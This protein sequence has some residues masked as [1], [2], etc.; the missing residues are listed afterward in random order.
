MSA[1]LTCPV[2]RATVS[3]GPQCRRCRADLSLLLTLEEQRQRY[4]ARAYHYA[5]QGDW[6]RALAIAHGVEALRSNPA[7]RRLL[8]AG[9]L[10]QGDFARAWDWLQT[11]GPGKTEE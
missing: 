1:A 3:S 2:C 7:A 6:Q 11:T 10:L 8:A 4:L 5:V 9:Y